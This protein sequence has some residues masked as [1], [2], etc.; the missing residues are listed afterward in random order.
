VADS[1][2]ARAV[3]HATSVHCDVI[4]IS[5]GGAGFFGLKAAI[6][7][8]VQAG[9]IVVTAAGNCVHLVVAPALYDHTIAVAATNGEDKPWHGSCHG[10]AVDISAPGEDVYRAYRNH[11]NDGTVSVEPSD[12][13]SYATAMVAGAAALWLG[14]HG[15]PAIEAARRRGETVHDVFAR[16]VVATSN[17]GTPGWMP[18]QFGRGILDVAALLK[19]DLSAGPPRDPTALERSAAAT[20]DNDI[21]LLARALDRSPAATRAALAAALRP[22]QRPDRFAAELL[23]LAY[24]DPRSVVA[25][26]DGGDADL[27]RPGGTP[28]QV[29]DRASSRLNGV[30]R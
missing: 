19:A 3:A 18:A 5:L 23:E 27:A 4:S 17:G 26:L 13:T 14:Y 25:M 6:D 7:N 20:D 22:G 1:Q 12:G 28:S 30:L 2:L 15:R 9:A 11:P 21:A 10:T 16:L 24:R 29:R 8:A